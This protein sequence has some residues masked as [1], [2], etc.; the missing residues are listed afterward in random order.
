MKWD[1]TQNVNDGQTIIYFGA[2]IIRVIK[3]NS[4]AAWIRTKYLVNAL[5]HYLQFESNLKIFI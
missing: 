5:V 4:D 3:L 1:C 2:K